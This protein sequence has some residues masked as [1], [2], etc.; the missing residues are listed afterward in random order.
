ML[1]KPFHGS[2]CIGANHLESVR[3]GQIFKRRDRLDQYREW[4]DRMKEERRA[5][6]LRMG[7]EEGILRQVHHFKDL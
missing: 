1:S 5:Y 3:A 7:V 4:V 2:G 6:L